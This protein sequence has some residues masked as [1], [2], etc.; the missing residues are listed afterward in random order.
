MVV[1]TYFVVNRQ[2]KFSAEKFSMLLISDDIENAPVTMGNN[3]KISPV[4]LI[5]RPAISL[6]IKLPRAAVPR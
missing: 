5:R 2:R 3:K 6:I 4:E 1:D